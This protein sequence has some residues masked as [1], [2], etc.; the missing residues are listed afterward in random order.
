M[1]ITSPGGTPKDINLYQAQKTLDN[2]RGAVREGG[3]MMLVAGCREGF[4]ER[5]LEAG[6]AGSARRRRSSIIR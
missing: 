2:V 5:R 6:W 4:G 3:V 1:A